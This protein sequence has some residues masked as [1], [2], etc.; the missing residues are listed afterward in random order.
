MKD[1]KQGVWIGEGEFPSQ[2]LFGGKI[3]KYCIC[4][5]AQVCMECLKDDME[6]QKYKNIA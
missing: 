1:P 2:D 3:G 6:Q 5:E 4:D